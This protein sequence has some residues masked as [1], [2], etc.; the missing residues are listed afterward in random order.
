MVRPDITMLIPHFIIGGGTTVNSFPI[1]KHN[2][3]SGSEQAQVFAS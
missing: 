1:R 2:S 3:I